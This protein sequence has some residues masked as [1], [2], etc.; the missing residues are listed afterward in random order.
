MEQTFQFKQK[1]TNLLEHY[2]NMNITLYTREIKANGKVTGVK[3]LNLSTAPCR[4]CLREN[5]VAILNLGT[6]WSYDSFTLRPFYPFEVSCYPLD[7]RLDEPKEIKRAECWV[8]YRCIL[9]ISEG[10]NKQITSRSREA[11]FIKGLHTFMFLSMRWDYVSEL[12]KQ[13]VYFSS[14][15]WCMSMES[16]SETIWQGKTEE[17]GEKSV[18]LPLCALQIPHGLLTRVRT[19]AFMVRGR[20]L[21][22]WITARSKGFKMHEISLSYGRW[23]QRQ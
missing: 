20:R 11:S 19:R 16:H 14:P 3:V 13:R 17:L 22:A 15:R 5:T 1:L 6:R 21:T 18:P 2:N 9:I 12:Q 8:R 23:L 10:R 7:T 4:L